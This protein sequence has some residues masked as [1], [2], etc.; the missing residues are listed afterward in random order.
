MLRASCSIPAVQ[1][2]ISSIRPLASS[3][4]S[5]AT[6]SPRSS[7]PAPS[8]PCPFAR[9]A[10]TSTPTDPPAPDLGAVI[11]TPKTRVPLRR[12]VGLKPKQRVARFRGT[13][14]SERPLPLAWNSSKADPVILLQNS[15]ALKSTQH[16]LPDYARCRRKGYLGQL[17]EQDFVT[18]LRFLGSEL[19]ANASAVVGDED[20]VA[21]EVLA[22]VKVVQDDIA[23]VGAPRSAAIDAAVLEV[24]GKT[25]DVRA[26]VKLASRG[27]NASNLSIDIVTALMRVFERL[28]H[29]YHA[30]A[31]LDHVLKSGV[32]PTTEIFTSVISVLSK[33]GDMAGAV[34]ILERMPAAGVEPSE[35]TIAALIHGYARLGDTNQA[36]KW[37]HEAVLRDIPVGVP[38]YTALI[39]CAM[40]KKNPADAARIFDAMNRRLLIPTAETMTYLM[41]T[42]LSHDVY[43]QAARWFYKFETFRGFRYTSGMHAALI[44]AQVARGDELVSWRQ[45]G[46]SI[47]GG[48]PATASMLLPLAK[49]FA[50]KH[51]NYLRDLF[52]FSEL[53]AEHIPTV[54]RKLIRVLLD[55]GEDASVLSLY[56]ELGKAKTV[57]TA[58]PA[59]AAEHICALAAHARRGELDNA[60]QAF[61]LA[62][63]AI[64]E[65]EAS[66]PAAAAG[67]AHDLAE[68]HAYV[69]VAHAV[70]GDVAAARKVL[71]DARAGGVDPAPL[72]YEAILAALRIEGKESWTDEGL[73][74]EIAVEMA[75]LGVMPNEAREPLMTRAMA[76]SGL[77]DLWLERL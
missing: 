2:R 17:T 63:Q 47:A 55:L 57:G 65:L 62:R 18:I 34:A 53:P 56:R 6:R 27:D 61:A 25:G 77:S 30:T 58:T 41:R 28:E 13:Q 72:A 4:P 64:T 52:R 46:A 11:L 49:L 69:A 60:L 37:H 43:T 3:R 33:T 44:E 51:P 42:H 32:V 35:E 5:L 70:K 74:K 9:N 71:V 48:M 36:N 23:S 40:T 14:L 15:F 10:S 68:V 39:H 12:P 21:R 1:A 19:E 54:L 50:G 29:A 26:A 59:T 22:R 31:L 20:L 38:I 7:Y 45:L 66:D 24:Y 8:C 16:Y 75:A 76:E 67:V 73:V